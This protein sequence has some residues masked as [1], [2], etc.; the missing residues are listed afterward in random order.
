MENNGTPTIAHNLHSLSTLLLF[1]GIEPAYLQPAFVPNAGTK[2]L[3]VQ[4]YT[5][6]LLFQKLVLPFLCHL[7]IVQVCQKHSCPASNIVL[8]Y[9]DLVSLLFANHHLLPVRKTSIGPAD[10]LSFAEWPPYCV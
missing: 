8:G 4:F 2:V 7:Q 1:I 10:P 5:K 6:Q 3:A 9:Q